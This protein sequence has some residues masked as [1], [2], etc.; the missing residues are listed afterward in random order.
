VYDNCT[1]PVPT[2]FTLT[3][4]V[5]ADRNIGAMLSVRDLPERDELRPSL[6]SAGGATYVAW[7]ADWYMGASLARY[8]DLENVAMFGVDGVSNLTPKIALADADHGAL[9]W[10]AIDSANGS[11]VVAPF[12]YEAGEIVVG[13]PRVLPHVV[14][15]A[16]RFIADIVHVEDA[17]YVVGWTEGGDVP[18]VYAMQIDFDRLSAV[19]APTSTLSVPR[20]EPPRTR[21]SNRC[22]H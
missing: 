9:A 12:T 18:H 5:D 21:R 8:P 11:I 10:H 1:G 20:S 2:A 4:P 15:P 16:S 22:S 14:E 7:E 19:T 3:A 17:R 6:A 13:E